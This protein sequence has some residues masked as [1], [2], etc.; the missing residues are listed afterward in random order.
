MPFTDAGCLFT[1]TTMPRGPILDLEI[2]L[3]RG[4]I[5]AVGKLCATIAKIADAC[6]PPQKAGGAGKA[7]IGNL[8][9]C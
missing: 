8:R 3:P 6:F 9:T 1:G 2:P 7:E 5:P 4:R